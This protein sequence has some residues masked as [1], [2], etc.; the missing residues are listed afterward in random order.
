MANDSYT[1]NKAP[2]SYIKAINK[3]PN[4]I[5]KVHNSKHTKLHSY[6]LRDIKNS[7]DLIIE[8]PLANTT[9]VSFSL[10]FARIVTSS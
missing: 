3:S 6:S 2:N 7:T 4:T 1:N 9:L 8:E 5:N 10:I